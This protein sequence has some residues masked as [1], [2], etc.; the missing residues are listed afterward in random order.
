MRWCIV[1]VAAVMTMVS[2]APARAA[3]IAGDQGLNRQVVNGAEHYDATA[4]TV[5][6][7]Q[8]TNNT[9][10]NVTSSPQGAVFLG[11]R[12]LGQGANRTM[13]WAPLYARGNGA[14]VRLE[15]SPG[16]TVRHHYGEFCWDGIKVAPGSGGWTV[17]DS[18][19]RHIRDDAIEADAQ[20][21]HDGVVRRSFLDGVHT[22]ISVTPGKG[23]SLQERAHIE[24]RDNVMSLGCGLDDGRPCEDR[25]KRLKF[26][27]ARPRGSGQAFKVAGS[28]QA[29]E[30]LFQGN[31]VAMGAE[32]V[33]GAWVE[34]GI[35]TAPPNL[36]FFQDLTVLPG[37][38]GNTFYWLGGCDFDGLEMTTLHGACVPARFELDPAVWTRAS[39]DR[40][41]WETEVARWTREVWEHEPAPPSDGRTGIA[42]PPRPQPRG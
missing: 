5:R 16:M 34:V 23:H 30:I 18:W 6:V 39:N 29:I 35:N 10:Y 7:E 26:G 42:L 32:P 11:G 41:A 27:W 21:A 4:A 38:T 1:P 22:L 13:T 40:A 14:C 31:V 9:G 36:R 33:D 20:G 19:L 25:D 2:S 12:T 3:A 28:G 15:N 17:E 24:L 37:S 8:G